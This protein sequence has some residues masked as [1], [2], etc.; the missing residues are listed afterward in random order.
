LPPRNLVKIENECPRRRDHRQ[1][2]PA[3]RQR[4]LQDVEDEDRVARLRAE[5]AL[6]V[7]RAGI[8]AADLENVDAM[9]PRHEV[10]ERQ[11][12]EEITDECGAK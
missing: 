6:D 10:A 4:A 2:R 5:R 3:G 8:A 7:G 1:Q 9:R 12:P 11:R